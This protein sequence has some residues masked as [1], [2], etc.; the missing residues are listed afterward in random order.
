MRM[1]TKSANH[2][3]LAGARMSGFD[4]SF[5]GKFSPEPGAKKLNNECPGSV[6]VK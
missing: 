1:I 3:K 6:L 2:D 4:D 5:Q